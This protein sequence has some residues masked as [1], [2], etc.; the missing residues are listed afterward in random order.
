MHALAPTHL[1]YD[2]DSTLFRLNWHEPLPGT[3]VPEAVVQ[4]IWRDQRMRAAGLRTTGGEPVEVIAPGELNTDGGPD[5]RMAR[6]RIGDTV[7]FGDVEIH[8]TSR[9]WRDHAHDTDARYNSV[10]LHVVL[11][12]DLWTGSLRRADGTAL[13]ELVLAPHLDGSLRDRLFRFFTRATP[14]RPCAWGFAGVPRADF[15]AWLRACAAERLTRR[16]ERYASRPDLH[17]AV[18]AEAAAALGYRPNAEPMRRL[19]ARVNLSDL[20]TLRSAQDR[21]ALLLGMAGLLPGTGALAALEDDVTRA[22]AAG[23]LRRFEAIQP[24]DHAPLVATEW[25]YARLR[26]ANFPELRIAQLAA[27]AA[28]GALLSGDGIDACANLLRRRAPERAFHDLFDAAPHPFWET[29]YRI[30][31]ASAAHPT[32]IGATTRR[33]VLVN[34]LLPAALAA[35]GMRDAVRG[36]ALH[37]LATLPAEDDRLTRSFTFPD[38]WKPSLLH[39]QGLHELERSYCVARRCLSCAVGQHLV[40]TD[41]V[42]SGNDPSCPPCSSDSFT[43]TSALTP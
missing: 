2:A 39:T 30:D 40:T 18:Y 5:F 16:A 1:F 24:R 34:V 35:A 33:R 25:Q 32:H 26:P 27:L 20:V 12:P 22:Y 28:P 41:A 4:E 29:H 17:T 43:S 36:H 42:S 7:W 10:V 21:E 13:P 23:L 11:Q 19:S 38:A 15:E 6:L 31:R 3:E 9:G 8:T 37:L 14:A